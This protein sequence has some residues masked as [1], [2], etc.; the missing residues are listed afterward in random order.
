MLRLYV[1]WRKLNRLLMLNSGGLEDIQIIFVEFRGKRYFKELDL[2]NG[3]HK[4]P[5]AER[6]KCKTAFPGLD[7]R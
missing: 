3:F 7:G 5:L 2:A 4:V 1:D 6:D